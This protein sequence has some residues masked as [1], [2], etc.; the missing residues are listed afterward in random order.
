[1]DTYDQQD[2]TADLQRLGLT[3]G[4]T[5]F[6]HS[7]LSTLGHVEGGADTV[8]TALLSVIGDSGTLAAPA[9][10]FEEDPDLFDIANQP[11]GMGRIS[12]RIRTHS[13]ARRSPHRTHS[14]SAIGPHSAELAHHGPS[15]W[16]AD[17]PFWQFVALDARI[18]M[19]GVSYSY[20]TFFHLI[21][22]LVQ[23]S[24]R[25]WIEYEGVL[26]ES[27]GS[28]RPLTT[29]TFRQTERSKGND[30]NKFGT[31]LEKKGLVQIR[32]VGNAIARLFK[33]SDALHLGIA[34]YRKDPNLF[35]CDGADQTLLKDGVR[36]R[37]QHYVVD[38]DKVYD[39]A[40]NPA[41]PSA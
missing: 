10:T 19:L 35:V 33:A 31:I 41:V 7:A 21:E 8:I 28:E 30:F 12:E 32:S 37:W 14:I 22:Q 25:E 29:R 6:V 13:Q 4:D 20:C 39:R 38:P 5:V 18:L 24:Y 1:M 36:H 40:I 3:A 26:R 34:E 17:G 9:F 15:A 23:V 2:L 16:A 11:S 27:N